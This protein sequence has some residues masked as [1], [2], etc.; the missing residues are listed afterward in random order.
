MPIYLT[1][2]GVQSFPNHVLGVPLAKQAEFQA[3]SEKLAWQNPRVVSFDQYLLR[4]DPPKIRGFS[5][6]LETAKGAVKP[7]YG[8]FRLPLV[9]TRTHSGVSFWGLVRPLGAP[10]PPG[11]STGPTGATGATGATGTTGT[12]GTTGSTGSTGPSSGGITAPSA[13]APRAHRASAAGAKSLTLQYSNDGGH[14]WRTLQVVRTQAG[15]AWT[16]T[17]NFARHRL[18]RVRWTSAAGRTYYGAPT[19]AYTTSGRVDY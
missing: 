6:G 5:S 19:R 18:W 8:G 9:V 4:D 12:T 13:V 16:A 1:E 2:F 17:G 15:G 10:A 7:V 14:V 3:I 11:G